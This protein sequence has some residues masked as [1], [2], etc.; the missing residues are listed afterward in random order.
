MWKDM[1][2]HAL[3]AT[4]YELKFFMLIS[5]YVM[6]RWCK[7]T[8][9]VSVVSNDNQVQELTLSSPN[10]RP[11]DTRDEVVLYLQQDNIRLEQELRHAHD[12]LEYYL[13]ELNSKTKLNHILEDKLNSATEQNNNLLT[14]L[15]RYEATRA[16]AEN[17]TSDARRVIALQERLAELEQDNR[18]MREQLFEELRISESKL[19]MAEETINQSEERILHL[20]RT[21]DDWRKK[22]EELSQEN[23][24]LSRANE[25]VKNLEIAIGEVK[26]EK[27]MLYQKL[28][29]LMEEKRQLIAAR[30]HLS[31]YV[32]NTESQNTKLQAK[33][34]QMNESFN[35]NVTRLVD[36]E[37]YIKNL[38]ARI[39]KLSEEVEAERLVRT[40][41]EEQN[42]YLKNQT[43]SPFMVVTSNTANNEA[44]GKSASANATINPNTLTAVGVMLNNLL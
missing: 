21:T 10:V 17:Q 36:K 29:D 18:E 37:N 41:L 11:A 14:E 31:S 33:I 34:R 27:Q 2:R 6:L 23:E 26:D 35:E 20:E 39:D 5:G 25:E 16:L 3:A 32:S 44:E 7:E 12:R 38:S 8:K 13:K 30:D 19:S 9:E 1:V 42:K 24:A 43:V 22:C 28:N 15:G 4:S 40:Q